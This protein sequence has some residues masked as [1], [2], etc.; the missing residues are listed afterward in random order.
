MED[1]KEETKFKIMETERLNEELTSRLSDMGREVRCLI[2][3]RDRESKE[4]AMRCSIE[5]KSKEE[6]KGKMLEDIQN[7]IS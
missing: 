3:E 7:L 5:T 1:E 4:N 6:N 2:D